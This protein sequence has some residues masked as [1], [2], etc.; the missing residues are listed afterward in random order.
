MINSEKLCVMNQAR[1]K[2]ATLWRIWNTA[3]NV[4]PKQWGK[5]LQVFEEESYSS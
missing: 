4:L 1:Q 3:R 2:V 5:P